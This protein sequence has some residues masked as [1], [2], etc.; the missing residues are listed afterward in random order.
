MGHFVFAQ[1]NKDQRYNRFQY[2]KLR[3]RVFHADAY[4]IYYPMYADS[5]SSFI[6]RQY[7]DAV[8]EV[9]K[10]MISGLDKA[11]N[12]VV[13]PSVDQYYESN[14]GSF[15]PQQ[16]T[17]PTLVVKGN[18]LVLSFTGSYSDLKAQLQ[19]TIARSVW[20]RKIKEGS[21]ENQAKGPKG[22]AIPMWFK[23]G[24]IRYFA[25]GWTVQ[26]EDALKLSFRQNSFLD[27]Y[28]VISYQPRLSGQALCYFL[29]E[30]YFKMAPA[31]VFNQLKK[32]DLQ[33]SL[34]LLT[35]KD[36][37]ILFAQCFDFYKDRFSIEIKKPISSTGYVFPHK[38]GIVRT[39][40]VSPDEKYIAY[41]ATA[42]GKRTVYVCDSRSKVS[43]KV[44][45]YTLPPWISDHSKDQYPLVRWASNGRELQIAMP[46]KGKVTIQRYTPGGSQIEA[47]KLYGVDG[48]HSFQS[49]S[50]RE[51]LLAGYRR[52]Q[53]DN[54][55][56]NERRDI[57]MPYT[58]D[59]Y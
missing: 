19:E 3:W 29:S 56:Y 49:L 31:Q 38:E 15:E 44:T 24:A 40:T 51:Y 20:E 23:E 52:G 9:K 5:L 50:D 13:Y 14:I 27:W 2:H 47:T 28:Q 34:R 42:K 22:E 43:I 25:H 32:K 54:V 48:I 39:I 1:E 7:P 21:M 35:K 11:P 55:T 4:H 37:N 53:S 33:R 12:I 10:R 41:T 36:L 45:E 58:T 26:A 17:L 46:V 16:Y 57:Y 8:S 6:A 59:I 18:R 30:K